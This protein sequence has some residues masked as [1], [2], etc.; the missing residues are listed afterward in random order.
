MG[1]VDAQ[2]LPTTFTLDI[3]PDDF[4]RY[5]DGGTYNSYTNRTTGVVKRVSIFEEIMEGDAWNLWG[6]HDNED[7]GSYFQYVMDKPTEEKIWAI[8]RDMAQRDGI[9]LDEELDLEDAINEVD[10]DYEIKNA[11]G[12]AI[13]D[14]DADDYV[15]HLQ[16]EIKSALEFYGNVS[17]FNSDGAK[18]QIDLSSL[19][20]VDDEDID[21][22]F[23][24]NLNK[25][26]GGYNLEG[27]LDTLISEDYI[28][29]PDYSPDDRWYPSPDYSVVNENV[30][31][32]LDDISI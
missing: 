13:N 30:R 24:D 6:H 12:S 8:V 1:I 11:I 26:G 17:F 19:V 32:R 31:Y 9:E 29:K 5:I 7:L 25:L 22:I 23:E 21:V 2:P 4:Y 10:N 28:E 15:N 14:A 16:D 18:I 20:D 27:V 3:T